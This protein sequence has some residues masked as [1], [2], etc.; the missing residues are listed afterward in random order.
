[1]YYLLWCVDHV[2]VE[3]L[4]LSL[5]G[6]IKLCDFGSATTERIQPNDTWSQS[7]RGLIEEEVNMILTNWYRVIL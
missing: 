4:L 3:N 6:E 7:K 5:K 1:M 2:Q